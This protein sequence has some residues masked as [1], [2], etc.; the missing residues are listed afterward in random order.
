LTAEAFVT[1]MLDVGFASQFQIHFTDALY[2]NLILS[3]DCH[4]YQNGD[5]RVVLQSLARS[6]VSFDIDAGL[7]LVLTL[8]GIS[9]PFGKISVT[10]L[11]KHPRFAILPEPV[12]GDDDDGGPDAEATFQWDPE[13][14]FSSLTPFSTNGTPVADPTAFRNACFQTPP[15][16]GQTLPTP[17]FTP[18][19]PQKFATVLEFPCN[20]CFSSGALTQGCG[21]AS[22]E[23]PE[24]WCAI[25]ENGVCCAKNAIDE[26]GVCYEPLNQGCQF[27][28]IS[29]SDIPAG[30]TN[31]VDVLF[32]APQDPSDQW[33]CDSVEKSGCMD[34]CTYDATALQ[35]LQVV[36]SAVDLDPD[37]C[38][39][40]VS[41]GRPCSTDAHCDDHNPCTADNCVFGGEFGTCS[42][43][44]LD[45]ACDDG[46]FC[47]G[48]DRCAL[49]ACAVH[50]GNPCATAGGCCEE[51]SDTCVPECPV[52]LPRCG[53]T[54]LQS[55]EQ[56]DDGNTVSGDGCSATCEIERETLDCGDA[57]ASVT[58]LWPPNHQFA[59][60]SI[61]GVRDPT[62]APVSISVTGITQD[63]PLL[64]QGD[65]N[66]CPDGLG[67]GTPTA[68]LRAERAGTPSLPGDGRVYHV[69][70]TATSGSAGE[71]TGTVTVCVPH[72]QR[73]GHACVDG[74][75]L[76][77]STGPCP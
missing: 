52:P 58:E 37:R 8:S 69:S 9:T 77:D 34:L 76:V 63:E 66:T 35:P 71:C 64:G 61:V 75:A 17:T 33:F 60:V 46:L 44:A 6:H 45:I 5:T 25:D 56:C 49:G 73:P 15:P 12:E 51:T 54:I 16:D 30:S 31:E 19:D 70:F 28:P 22:T 39:G 24:D 53:N 65:G 40:S 43:T 50:D 23:F 3:P 29:P 72:D 47:N 1:P 42:Y 11:E 27:W 4:L 38:S 59:E 68:R 41:Q 74:G 10:V 26:N 13:P 57:A 14:A 32:P 55:G 18:D 2:R 48:S 67:V 7:N 36:Q 21:R 20:V 62:G